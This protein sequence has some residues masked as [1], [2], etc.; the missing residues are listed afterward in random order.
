MWWLPGLAKLAPP[1]T[2]HIHITLPLLFSHFWF[3]PTYQP[4]T[5][6]TLEMREPPRLSLSVSVCL[7]CLARH[8]RLVG[9]FRLPSFH[10]IS[11]SQV[12][13]VSITHRESDVAGENTNPTFSPPVLHTSHAITWSSNILEGRHGL[14]W[15]GLRQK[16][17]LQSLPLFPPD[18]GK[19]CTI[20][21]NI[22]SSLWV[23]NGNIWYLTSNI[24]Y[25][26]KDCVNIT[27]LSP[28][29]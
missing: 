26:F 20:I 27:I 6:G 21:K 2:H 17:R 4:N 7:S 29:L 8:L 10:V 23:N 18:Q 9:S 24:R 11:E 1:T 28:A 16:S 15:A 13:R 12:S 25:H 19:S 14:L 22:F 3:F 5:A